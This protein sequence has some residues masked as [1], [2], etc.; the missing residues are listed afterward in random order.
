MKQSNGSNW[1]L[2][3][4]LGFVYAKFSNLEEDKFK[5]KNVSGI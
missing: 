4:F 3:I 1:I 5:P 2:E